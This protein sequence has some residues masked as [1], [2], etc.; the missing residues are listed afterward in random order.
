ME[1]PSKDICSSKS[2]LLA[3]R[4]VVLG[5]CGSVGAVRLPDLAR[6][7]MRHG[8]E[9]YAVMTP[10]AQ[11]IISPA[12]MEW[13]TGNP[14]VT[15]LTGGI[16]H[17]AL[18]GGMPGCADIVLVAPATANT[19]SKMA[20]G[21][22][23]TPVTTLAT[24]AIGAKLPV[25]VVP[26]MHGSMYCHPAVLENIMRLESMGIT[27]MHPKESEGKAKIADSDSI[28]DAVVSAL[29]EKDMRGVRVLVT[30][31]PTRSYLDPVRY[32][33][34]SS[35]GR[36]GMAMASEAMSRGADVTLVLGPTPV[37]PPP[38]RTVRAETTEE[39]MAAVLSELNSSCYDLLVM[40]AAPLDFSFS[41]KRADKISSDAPLTVSLTPLPK[42]VREARKAAPDLFIIGF[43]AEH[44]ITPEELEKRAT[45]RLSDSGM[46]MIVANDLSHPG[47]GF[48]CETNEVLI[49]P[50]AG[51]RASLPKMP[52]R[53]V[54]RAIL[55]QYLARRGK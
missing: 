11:A 53:S 45:E 4:K 15:Q 20:L 14:V 12:L 30:A 18:G 21:I 33:T 47:A 49:I 13:A 31:G 26:A 22:D 40:A 34:N 24:T 29:A 39:M 7:L 16:E 54:A 42:V 52:K 41:K 8:A 44:K 28:V 2:S 37:P 19:I 17:V 50:K 43:K 3:G 38:C 6:E 32:L 48:E 23:D 35:S 1:H 10:A 9:V 36:M 51:K 5:I 55:D 25:I 27:V 46:D